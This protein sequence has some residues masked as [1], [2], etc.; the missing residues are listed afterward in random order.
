[1]VQR[2]GGNIAIFCNFYR[3]IP[4][5]DVNWQ[6][7]DYNFWNTDYSTILICQ[8]HYTYPIQWNARVVAD[9]NSNETAVDY[10]AENGQMNQ[11]LHFESRESNFVQFFFR[12]DVFDH[13]A[14]SDRFD[15]SE[16]E[17]EF[18]GIR[19]N[20]YRKRLVE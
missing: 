17:K 9:T 2:E 18:R 15:R 8:T 20:K 1:M 12:V 11:L 16:K 19:I 13:F 5:A 6:P 4:C 3:K 10:F 14:T 7:C